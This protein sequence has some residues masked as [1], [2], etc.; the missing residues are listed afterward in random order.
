MLSHL[1]VEIRIY[2]SI[3][4]D[5]HLIIL[6]NMHMWP[7]GRRTK[8]VFSSYVKCQMFWGGENAVT[9]WYIY[10]SFP[11]WTQNWL[12]AAGIKRSKDSSGI[13][14][15]AIWN[16]ISL[17]GFSKNKTSVTSWYTHSIK[18][19]SVT[20]PVVLLSLPLMFA[21]NVSHSTEK[22]C[23]VNFKMIP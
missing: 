3:R 16:K 18:I 17:T 8:L 5:K 2:S 9:M 1:I 4:L 13:L 21:F 11:L 20:A 15:K 19:L 14:N 23:P 22:C 7:G 12:L 10:W 6:V